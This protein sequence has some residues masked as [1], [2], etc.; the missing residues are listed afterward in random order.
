MLTQSLIY[1]LILCGVS[2]LASDSSDDSWDE[3]QISCCDCLK[4]FCMCLFW[5]QGSSASADI[6]S[7]ATNP[8][9]VRG[10]LKTFADSQ[11]RFSPSA[12]I[13]AFV[14]KKVTFNFVDV[15][16]EYL[17]EEPTIVVQET[18]TLL[19]PSASPVASGKD[20]TDCFAIALKIYNYRPAT[21]PREQQIA[22]SCSES[23]SALEADEESFSAV[24]DQSIASKHDSNEV[25]DE[26]F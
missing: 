20:D 23:S 24:T 22:S 4:A 2:L 17:P 9:T 18:P 26:D 10:I 3:E 16:T 6:P 25:I 7:T 15:V 8:L 14:K 19:T 11:P 1:L 21:P 13:D 12:S 5:E